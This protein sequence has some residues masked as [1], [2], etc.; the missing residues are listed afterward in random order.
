MV[1]ITQVIT[2]ST[3]YLSCSLLVVTVTAHVNYWCSYSNNLALNSFGNPGLI[4]PLFPRWCLHEWNTLYAPYPYGPNSKRDRAPEGSE[5]W[6]DTVPAGLWASLVL[7]WDAGTEQF[8]HL[9]N[10]VAS[11]PVKPEIPTWR[12]NFTNQKCPNLDPFLV[13]NFQNCNF[14]LRTICPDPERQLNSFFFF[15]VV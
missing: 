15:P 13:H 10:H 7:M 2:C 3:G 14:H 6:Q 1:H 5:K 11:L 4:P 8:Q 9:A 12:K